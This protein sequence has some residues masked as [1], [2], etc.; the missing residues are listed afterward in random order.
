MSTVLRTRE[1]YCPS[2][3]GNYYEVALPHEMHELLAEARSWGV[4]RFS[5]WFDTVDLYNV[6]ARR[7]SR[8]YNMPE[9]VWDKKFANFQ[10]AAQAGLELGLTI[11]PNHVF[12]EQVTP[13]TAAETGGEVFG[14]LVCPSKPGVTEM[15]LD[16]Y[17]NIFRDLRDRGS[18]FAAIS[19]CPYDYGGC[20]CAECA[21]W[22]VTFGKLTVEIVKLARTF[23]GDVE[24]NLIGWWWTDADHEQFTAWA[25]R[26]V[27][28]FFNA[29]ANHIQYGQT[30]YK[31][32]IV[33]NACAERAFVHIGY[34]ETGGVDVYGH[35]GPPIGPTR[36]EKTVAFLRSRKA[37]GFMAYSEGLCDEL[38]M[39]VLAGLSSGQFATADDVLGTYVDRYF[40]GDRSGW[41]AWLHT[42]GEVETVDPAQARK[43]FDRLVKTSRDN[44]RIRALH[45]KLKMCEA[46][47]IVRSKSEWDAERIRAADAFWLA[48]ER[49][50][51]DIWR[52]GLGRHALKFDWQAPD[53]AREKRPKTDMAI[54]DLPA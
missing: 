40:G 14:Q 47:A 26:E 43:A 24:A 39:A 17:A 44:W 1:L 42:M 38:N 8:F 41:V 30:Q 12:Q 34:G 3:F 7:D 36:I 25:D 13:E 28:G 35:Y 49:L 22:I 51:R 48:K 29:F 46:D 21:P 52:R 9:A 32:R 10:C 18:R 4:N 11:T 54:D 15:I 45:E 19:A 16:N 50:W 20:K 23:F 5:D 27:P 31:Q 2:H 33:P 37:G 53:W 6:Y